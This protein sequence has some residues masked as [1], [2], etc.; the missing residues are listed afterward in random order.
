MR[1][2]QRQHNAGFTLAELLVA[3]TILA[4]ILGSVYTAFSS[5]VNIWKKGESNLH[6][7]Q[8][9][10]TALDIMTREMQN[11]VPGAGY[12]FTGASD[13]FSFYATTRPMDVEEGAEPRVLYI[14][15]RVKSDPKGEGKLL[16]R[17][18]QLV[19]SPLPAK[20]PRDGAIDT[21][22]IEL[23]NESQFEL[24]KGVKRF[25]LHYYWVAPTEP[26]DPLNPQTTAP[27]EFVIEDE[28]AEGDGIPQAIRIDLTMLDENA[29]KGETTFTTYAVTHGPSDKREDSSLSAEEV[30]PS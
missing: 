27:A 22:I 21:S 23:G 11:M 9:A 14:R 26:V 8:D 19:E 29:E 30:K 10:R 4:V 13:E 12:L 24:A 1:R 2:S 16:I 17:E 6:T 18:E 15:Y 25:E 7:F 5:S 28:L 20:P 3:S